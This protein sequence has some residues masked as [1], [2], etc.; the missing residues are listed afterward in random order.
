MESEYRNKRRKHVAC[1]LF[2]AGLLCAGV[3]V[4]FKCFDTMEVK[5]S[6]LTQ[7]QRSSMTSKQITD[8][9]NAYDKKILK[10]HLYDFADVKIACL[11]DSI[12][13][14][15]NGATGR[16]DGLT[17]PQAMQEALGAEE[18]YNLGIGGSSISNYWSN[19]MVG[20]YMEI[21][22]DSDIIIVFGGLNDVFSGS[23]ANIGDVSTL[24]PNTFCG[25]LDALLTGIQT[26]YPDSLLILVTPMKSITVEEVS[27]INPFMCPMKY[28]V[29]IMLYLAE[30]HDVEV[31]DLYYNDFMNSYDKEVYVAYMPGCHPVDAGYRVLGEH[32]AKEIVRIV[33]EA[34]EL[35]NP[36]RL[37]E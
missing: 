34:E 8:K 13:Q 12:T 27:M 26:N 20:R 17:Y 19:A 33:L 1:C 29:D 28:Y 6:V 22:Q 18:V 23:F 16:A 32:I 2:I 35:E 30:K 14:G 5:E 21:P 25:D 10:R 7:E 37:L 11:G 3:V 9:E 24:A 4:W 36:D 31:I 15:I